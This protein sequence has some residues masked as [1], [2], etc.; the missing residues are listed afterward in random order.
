M[1]NFKIVVPSYNCSKWIGKTINSLKTQ[2]MSNFTCIIMDDLS[3]DDTYEAA[4]SLT[5]NDERFLVNKNKEKKYPV[6]NF[7]E[8]L[9][10]LKAEKEDI[11]VVV[12]GDDWLFDKY[13]LMKVLNTYE[14]NDCLMTYGSFVEYPSGIQHPYY[15]EPYDNYIVST[16]FF[17]KAPWKASH[18]RTCKAKLW[19]AVKYTDLID[20]RTGNFYSLA[21]DV[22][23]TIPMLEMAGNRSFHISD[24]L[25]VYNK[26]NPL[27]EMYV[28]P[29]EQV[30]TCSLIMKNK[31]YN[32]RDFS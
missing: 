21:G 26:Q 9:K 25:Y 12:D 31:K 10:L 14:Q 11:C 22:A 32:R 28:K 6:G 15:L 4:V 23:A 19:N 17:R 13:S 5:K 29:K 1:N 16:N 2:T 30:E 3:T 7:Y 24:T 8:G 27:S 18:L 20:P